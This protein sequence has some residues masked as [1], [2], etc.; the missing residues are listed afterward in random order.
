MMPDRCLT[1]RSMQTP[2]LLC[3]KVHQSITIS[4]V[5]KSGHRLSDVCILLLFDATH[6]VF[7][8]ICVDSG[9]TLILGII[10]LRFRK[11]SHRSGCNSY[12]GPAALP[13]G[14]HCTLRPGGQD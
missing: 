13:F 3:M 10:R 5:I 12:V 8:S 7:R 14:M 1:H 4:F 9:F 6:D 11:T 2:R